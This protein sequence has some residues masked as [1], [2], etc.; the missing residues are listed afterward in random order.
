M[1]VVTDAGDR[2]GGNEKGTHQ[3]WICYTS[4]FNAFLLCVVV[5]ET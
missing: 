4:W 2:G 5:S 3:H 1:C